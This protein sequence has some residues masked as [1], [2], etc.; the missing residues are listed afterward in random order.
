MLLCACGTQGSFAPE[1]AKPVVIDLWHYYNGP[2]KDAFDLLVTEFNETVGKAKGV[3][4]EAFNRGS[5]NELTD[6]V[7]AATEKKPGSD[8]APN[9]FS[10]YADTA[11]MIDRKGLLAPLDSYLT[12]E[13]LAQYL[14]AYIDEGRLG[15]DDALKIMPTA[16]ATEVF[17]LNKTD[18]DVFSAET[19]ASLDELATFEGLT[20]VSERY[21]KWSDSK[22]PAI[23]NDGK[24]F[25]GRDAMA[26]YMLIGGRQLG[27]ELFSV[28]NSGEAALCEDTTILRKL[29]D[30]YYVPYVNGWFA[31]NGR[32]RSDDA[33]VGDIVALV[34]SATTATFFP[35]EVILGD[36][37][38]YPIE[39][40]ALPAPCFAQGARSAVQ[41]GAGMVVTKATPE[42]ERASMLFLKWFTEAERN[43]R[44]SVTSG[45][46]PVKKEANDPARLEQAIA[47]LPSISGTLAQ[48]LRVALETATTHE[49]CS[50]S[51]SSGVRS[52]FDK[53]LQDKAKADAALVQAMVESG[54]DRA[55]AAQ[56]LC[57]DENFEA[58]QAGFR[59]EL[60]K[61]Q[62]GMQE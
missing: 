24:A 31:A 51:G 16:K 13:E 45:Y 62:D 27:C 34:G 9:I 22:T 41:Q 35:E 52:L 60:Q 6:S 8:P 11:K 53:S 15:A 49:L 43:L 58:W 26:N 3:V 47:E 17:L 44:F 37:D 32:F 14:P 5:V 1:P 55:Q 7:I 21:Y 46:L 61:I 36:K 42:Q 23:P 20:A 59:A 12:P 4:V 25:F 40:L 38:S 39:A 54:M 28:G 56:A 10:A 29:W 50:F 48:T 18:W 33:T 30:H 2:Q 19:G 57:T